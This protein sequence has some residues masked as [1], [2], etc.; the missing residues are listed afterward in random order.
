MTLLLLW[1]VWYSL[2]VVL[3]MLSLTGGEWHAVTMFG[4]GFGAAMVGFMTTAVIA[5]VEK[6]PEDDFDER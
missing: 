3:L 5:A 2:I 6:L 1:G 4:A